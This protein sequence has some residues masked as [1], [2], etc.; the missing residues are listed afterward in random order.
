MPSRYNI[1]KLLWDITYQDVVLFCF[2]FISH[3][4]VVVESRKQREQT[5]LYSGVRYLV[6]TKLK[7]CCKF[8]L[9][10]HFSESPFGVQMHHRMWEQEGKGSLTNFVPFSLRASRMV[11]LASLNRNSTSEPEKQEWLRGHQPK[12]KWRNNL[13]NLSS[14]SCT[15]KYDGD[16]NSVCSYSQ[17][18]C[19]AST[20]KL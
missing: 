5:V 8:F 2:P 14:S 10:N 17:V 6:L 1:T 9:S 15:W 18:L 12:P 4:S 16:S 11:F 19:Q 20:F 7:L 3:V 13:S